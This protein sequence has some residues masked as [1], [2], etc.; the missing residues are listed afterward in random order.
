MRSHQRTEVTRWLMTSVVRPRAAA[1]MP[2]K[3]VRSVTAS[4]LAVASSKIST[5]GSM[6]RA[7]A[8]VRRWRWPPERLT[9]RSPT[10]VS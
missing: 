7:R 1:R 2:S 8:M 3:S 5:R 9:P 4:T 10:I 6:A